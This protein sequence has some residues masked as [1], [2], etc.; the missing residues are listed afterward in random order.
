MLEAWHVVCAA[1]RDTWHDLLTTAVVNLMWLG[2]TLTGVMAP[3]AALALFAVGNRLAHGE[4]T[5][6]RD[7]W[8]ALRRH[9]G[10]GWRWGL[11]QVGVLFVLVGDVL[12]TGRLAGDS[13]LGRLIQ[14]FYLAGLAVWLLWQ[15]YT[16][17]FLFEQEEPHLGM[18]LRNGALLLGRNP[19]F[20][21]ALGFLLLALLAAGI[22]FFFVTTAAGGVFL[23]LVATHAV[24]N[25]LG[26]QG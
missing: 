26:V 11:V 15:L 8:L 22:V 7:F 21:L 16:L 1:V 10:L 9:V 3:P 23:A 20:S 2:L 17:A 6:P 18:A 14:G 4:P 24:R 19:L 12:L 13:A 25:R 5:D